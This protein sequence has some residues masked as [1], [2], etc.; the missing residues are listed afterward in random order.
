M[1]DAG[2]GTRG[3]EVEDGGAGGFAASAG[4]GGDGDEGEEGFVDWETFAE[5]GVDEVEEVGV[6]V[7][8]VEVHELGGI[9]YG[10]AADG[11]EGVGLVGLGEGNGFFDAV[12]WMVSWG[13]VVMRVTYEVSFGSTRTPS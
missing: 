9:D 10:A 13:Q 4:G 8:G 7:A 6:G 5:G 2:F 3:G 12:G 11:E 1:C